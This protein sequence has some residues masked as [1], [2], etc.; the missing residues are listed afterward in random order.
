LSTPV[1]NFSLK[2]VGNPAI[3]RADATPSVGETLVS[4]DRRQAVVA[5]ASRKTTRNP[6][7]GRKGQRIIAGLAVLQQR[8]AGVMRSE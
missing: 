8:V 4:P 2:P 6:E 7:R 3:V 1:N 5:G